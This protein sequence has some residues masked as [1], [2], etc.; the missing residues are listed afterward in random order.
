MIQISPNIDRY[1]PT[2]PYKTKTYVE[3]RIRIFSHLNA[4]HTPGPDPNSEKSVAV[5]EGLS[6]VFGGRIRRRRFIE[7]ESHPHRPAVVR[8]LVGYYA[9]L[10]DEWR[11]RH[12]EQPSAARWSARHVA[13]GSHERGR[14]ALRRRRD[15]HRQP[16]RRIPARSAM[17]KEDKQARFRPLRMSALRARSPASLCSSPRRWGEIFC[18]FSVIFLA[19]CTV[20]W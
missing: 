20:A 2:N 17:I 14:G 11:A 19:L 16:I 18:G 6:A 13:R 4:H 12:G 9:R 10:R 1:E 8:V 5:G 3:I 15:H 7:N